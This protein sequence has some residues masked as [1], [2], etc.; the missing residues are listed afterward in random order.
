MIDKRKVLFAVYGTLC[1]ICGG[2]GLKNIEK[3]E[4]IGTI[5]ILVAAFVII[6]ITISDTILEED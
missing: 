6:T 3:E 5:L 2:V 1:V 4:N